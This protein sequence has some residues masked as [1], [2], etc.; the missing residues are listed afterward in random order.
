MSI[1]SQ[2]EED[3]KEAF[4]AHNELKISTFRMLKSALH[5]SEIQK[6][7]PLSEEDIYAVLNKEIKQ[8]KEAAV[9]YRQGE[10]PEL[11]QKEENEIKIISLY[12]PTPL[13]DAE[14]TK[15]VDEAIISTKANSIS[16]LGMVM[17][18]AMP[19]LKGKAA[20]DK[21]SQIVKNKLRG[22][23]SVQDK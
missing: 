23:L 20:G 18:E 14:I 9:Q 5:N 4:R 8:R 21:V 19:K 15:V 16:D 10:R 13:T 6:R 7:K 17:K 1:L 3:Y 12:L 11:A 22:T 2:I